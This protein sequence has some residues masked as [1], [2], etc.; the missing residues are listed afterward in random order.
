MI[1]SPEGAKEIKVSPEWP[2]TGSV[3]FDKVMLRYR[4]ELDH[5]LKKLSFNIESG[6]KVGVVGRTGA[7]KSTMG[8]VLSRILEIES[9]SVKIDGTE[10]SQVNIHNLRSKI[11]VIPQ[12]P[13]IFDGT[14]KFN[15]DPSGNV[16]DKEIEAILHEA[17][18]DDLLKRTPEKKQ[19]KDEELD[20]SDN[21]GNQVGI[22]FKLNDG[23]SSLSAG[24]KQLICICRA[25]LRKNKIIILDEATANIDIK[26]EEKI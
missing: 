23:G 21:V 9:G 2:T 24:E 15:L 5:T 13:V 25:V 3:S 4:P 8:L 12:D 18:L 22:Y 19:K 6:H 26:T 20:T 17:G 16:D 14:V 10:I 7:G 1:V 11:T